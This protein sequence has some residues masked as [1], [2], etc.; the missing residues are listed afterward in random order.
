MFTSLDYGLPTLLLSL[1]FRLPLGMFEMI[2]TNLV[3]EAKQQWI[4][5]TWTPL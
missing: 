3:S 5:V 2:E 4:K 1:L